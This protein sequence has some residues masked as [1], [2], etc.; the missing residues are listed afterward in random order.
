MEIE[1]NQLTPIT[2]SSDDIVVSYFTK[3]TERLLCQVKHLDQIIQDIKQ[4]YIGPQALVGS[5]DTISG[6]HYGFDRVAKNYA[7]L[8]IGQG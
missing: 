2:T 4:G 7:D 6:V 1:E 8:N 3:A 5:G